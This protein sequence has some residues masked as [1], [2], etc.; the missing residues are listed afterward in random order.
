[1][2]S[3]QK[4]RRIMEQHA[5]DPWLHDSFSGR[6]ISYAEADRYARSLA[7]GMRSRGVA[8]GDRVG[9]VLPNSAEFALCYLAA[10]YLGAVV[11]P[12]NIQVSQREI[13]FIVRQSGLR[14][15]VNA[16]STAPLVDA[17]PAAELG[18]PR[19]R[20]IPAAEAAVEGVG[21]ADAWS[22]ASAPEPGAEGWEPFAGVSPEDIYSITFTSGT[23]GLPKGVVQRISALLDNAAAF[24]AAHGFGPDRRFLHV[25]NMAYM[26]GF[27]NTLLL[28]LM[29]GASVV[30]APAFDPL[31]M[32]RFWE[33]VIRY[34]ADTF[35]L[36]PTM[37]AGLSRVRRSEAGAEYCRQHVRTICVGTAPLPLAVRSD[38]ETKFGVPLYE[39]YGLSELLLITTNSAG[40][41]VLDG[42]VGHALPQVEIAVRD[43][44]GAEQPRGADGELLVRTPFATA[45]YLD[46]DSGGIAAFD[47]HDWFPTGDIGHLDA[48]GNLFIT[49]RKKD[50]IIRGGVN[51]SPRAIE[52]VLL[53]HP[54]V[55]NVAVI[56]LPHDLYGE[57]VAA[58]VCPRPGFALEEQRSDLIQFCRDRLSAASVPTQ[59]IERTELP[60]NSTGKVQKQRL[61]DELVETM[62]APA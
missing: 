31:S 15:L 47:A 4:L 9:F 54:V 6:S 25:M 10:L 61:R 48:A 11:V 59:W 7:E 22:T 33:P 36:A 29:A 30:L 24:N 2:N 58:V 40:Q 20:L 60:T 52:E 32:L 38:F 27:L 1:M 51:I 16:P 42:S 41:P 45:G 8:H 28:P 12:V 13:D 21:S 55:A 34:R 37:L 26:A 23:T 53:T 62:K 35:W 50:L 46:Y 56:G 5:S 14:L 19:W 49:A 44:A 17:S 18:V 39:S 43:D 3:I 57:Q